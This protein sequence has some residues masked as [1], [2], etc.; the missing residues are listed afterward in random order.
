[1]RLTHGQGQAVFISL[2]VL[3][4]C[5]VMC[6]SMTILYRGVEAVF[7]TQFVRALVIGYMIAWPTAWIIMPTL[8]RFVSRITR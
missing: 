8:R 6:T 1:M 3:I 2:M 4:M 5:T 7:T